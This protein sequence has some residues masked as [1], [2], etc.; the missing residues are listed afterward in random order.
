LLQTSR[1]YALALMEDLDNQK[2][3][4]RVGDGRVLR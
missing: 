1:K 2:V 3:T 4:R